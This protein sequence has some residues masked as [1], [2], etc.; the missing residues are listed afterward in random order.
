MCCMRGKEESA[1]TYRQE[2]IISV[3]IN[4]PLRQF[5]QFRNFTLPSVF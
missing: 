2:F 5:P 3:E 1:Y 4:L